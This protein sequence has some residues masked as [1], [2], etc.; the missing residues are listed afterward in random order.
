MTGKAGFNI[1]VKD[2]LREFGNIGTGSAANA[3]SRILNK[4][5][6]INIPMVSMH[7]INGIK[8]TL[9]PE[10]TIM[11]ALYFEILGEADACMM[12][13]FD[14]ISIHMIL[15]HL[16]GPGSRGPGKFADTEISCLE[17]LSNI[18]VCSYTKGLGNMLKIR[19]IPSIPSFSYDYI[20]ALIEFAIIR[21]SLSF[22][23][24]LVIDTCINDKAGELNIRA[25]LFPGIMLNKLVYDRYK[26]SIIDL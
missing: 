1:L 17:E 19:L 24:S 23:K 16:I 25:L 14:D 10:N 11:G 26:I 5:I 15:E 12:L 9:F 13:I 8:Q 6:M 21:Q 2:M 7:E 18:I 3:L 22:K 20:H 4:T